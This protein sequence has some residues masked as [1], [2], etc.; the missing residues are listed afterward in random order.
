MKKRKTYEKPEV[1]KV[2]LLL[3]EVALGTGCDT[4]VASSPDFG[5]CQPGVGNTCDLT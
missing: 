3:S 2:E 4:G 5:A 1:R